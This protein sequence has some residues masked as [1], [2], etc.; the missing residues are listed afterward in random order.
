MRQTGEEEAVARDEHAERVAGCP[1]IVSNKDSER[2]SYRKRKSCYALSYLTSF[3]FD[4]SC[5]GVV[6][7]RSGIFIANRFCL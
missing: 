6:R 2:E 7:G 5:V 4:F 1:C 3:C